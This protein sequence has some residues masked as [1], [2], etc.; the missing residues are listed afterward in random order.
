MTGVLSC[1]V[2]SLTVDCFSSATSC[3][4]SA[5]IEEVSEAAIAT[6]RVREKSDSEPIRAEVKKPTQVCFLAAL[7]AQGAIVANGA[8][9]AL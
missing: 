6:G 1:S 4:L 2:F 3:L 7:I 5:V 8:F 9:E